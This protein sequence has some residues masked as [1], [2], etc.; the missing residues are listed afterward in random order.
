[1]YIV[2]IGGSVITEKSRY[3]KMRENVISRLA[4]EFIPE[5]SILIHGAGSFGHYIADKFNLNDGLGDSN[6]IEYARVALDLQEL[7]SAIIRALIEREKPAITI[8]VHSFH[9]VGEE[10]PHRRFKDY[11]ERGIVPVT[12]GDV[13]LD[14]RKGMGIC[15]GDQIAFHL[16]K[17]L[18][19][20]K[21]IFVTDVDGIYDRNPKIYGDAK[22]LGE[23]SGKEKLNFSGTVPDV[24]GSMEG[25]LRVMRAI[26]KLG[27]EVM[28]INGLVRGRLRRA[29]RGEDV[30]GTRVLA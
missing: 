29:M 8:P 19:P 17:A 2:K 25:K 14:P 12:Y 22:L 7:N 3:R 5:D 6:R 26:A 23:V 10:F 15:S 24:T 16:S 20:D 11:M 27:I 13:V 1:M 21:V 9:M 4:D 30:K 28:V 18:R